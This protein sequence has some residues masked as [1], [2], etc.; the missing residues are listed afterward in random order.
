[1]A[2]A[3]TIL[4][5]AFLLVVAFYLVM[6]CA[7]SLWLKRWA[8]VDVTV[9]AALYVI[10]VI[11]GGAVVGVPLSSWLLAFSL[12]LFFSLALTKRVTELGDLASDGVDMLPRRGYRRTDLP[13][14]QMLGVASGLV[15]VLVLALYINSNESRTLYSHPQVLWML[16]PIIL[17]WVSRLW[18]LAHRQQ[19]HEDPV[20]YALSDP[21][22]LALGAASVVTLVWAL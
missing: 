13:L 3:A 5:T 8:I 18:L 7:Y 22:S 11:A 9:L 4:P 15:A 2:L 21:G 16:I 19:L 14:L 12:F 10:R 17:L 6:T 1:L 20:V